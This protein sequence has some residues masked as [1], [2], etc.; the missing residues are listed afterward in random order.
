MYVALIG[1]ET[2]SHHYE[3]GCGEINFREPV[4]APVERLQSAGVETRLCDV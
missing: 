4:L 2:I 1:T 3:R